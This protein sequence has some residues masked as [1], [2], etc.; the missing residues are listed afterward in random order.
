MTNLFVV[1][2]YSHGTS[3]PEHMGPL[4]LGIACW[5]L[6]GALGCKGASTPSA[7]GVDGGTHQSG[8]AES[9]LRLLEFEAGVF[10]GAPSRIDPEVRE[11]I[12]PAY[13]LG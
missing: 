6:F 8:L 1:R 10:E 5:L 9:W 12:G 7:T 2:R 4:A 13:F 11:S 3:R